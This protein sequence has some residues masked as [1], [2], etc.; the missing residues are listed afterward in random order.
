M[1]NTIED[2]VKTLDFDTISTMAIKEDESAK[3]KEHIDNRISELKMK[4]S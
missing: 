4:K 3:N 2:F 1:L